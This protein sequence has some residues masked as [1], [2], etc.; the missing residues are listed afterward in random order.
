MQE[1]RN[2]NVSR[3]YLQ[4]AVSDNGV[5]ISSFEQKRIFDPFYRLDRPGLEP[6]DEE[7]MGMGLAVVKELVELHNGRIW[8]ESTPGVGSVFQVSIP[9]SQG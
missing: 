3:P 5:G 2:G 6:E 7:G 4:M 1:Q 9:A 8:V